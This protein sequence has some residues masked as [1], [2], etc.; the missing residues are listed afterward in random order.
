MIEII[1]QEDNLGIFL[2]NKI[3]FSKQNENDEDFSNYI[4]KDFKHGKNLSMV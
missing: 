4:N 2:E 3:E 1:K